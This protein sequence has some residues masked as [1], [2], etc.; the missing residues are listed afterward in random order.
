MTQSQVKAGDFSAL[1]DDYSKYRPAYCESVLTALLALVGRSGADLDIVD[2]GAGTG[3]WTRMMAGRRPRSITAVEPNA[4]MREAGVADSQRLPIIWREGNGEA[5]GLA[6]ASADLLTMASS[7]HWVDFDRGVREF[8]RVL[9]PGGRFAALWNPRHIESSPLLMEI[10][11]QLT[12]LKP[13]LKRVS[14]GRSGVTEGLTERLWASGLFDDVVY[15]EGRHTARLAPAQYIGAWRSVN[16][17]QAQLGPAKFAAFL[18]FVERK[19]GHLPAVESVYATRMWT[20]RRK[21]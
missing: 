20:A 2:V 15:L 10:E 9:R 7:F 21:G 4:A 19:V 18:D 16:D 14:S 11:A 17:I 5:T 13:D 8:A 6:D 12:A 3:I 1:A